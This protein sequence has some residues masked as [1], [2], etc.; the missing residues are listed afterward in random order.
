MTETEILAGREVKYRDG[1]YAIV[2]SNL[3]EHANTHF[4][5]VNLKTGS[6]SSLYSFNEC[7]AIIGCAQRGELSGSF[8]IKRPDA[9]PAPQWVA[10][11]HTKARRKDG[12]FDSFLTQ[13]VPLKVTD[14][15]HGRVAKSGY[16][17]RIPTQYMVKW[18][19]RW[20]RVYAICYSNAATLYIGPKHDECMTVTVDWE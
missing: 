17:S 5:V 3:P 1:D 9:K 11:V 10:R 19:G 6:E 14:V 2:P 12:G 13:R 20:M 7:G 8:D 16:G 15:P 4:R 18:A